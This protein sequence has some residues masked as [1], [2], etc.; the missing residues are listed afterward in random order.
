MK[1]YAGLLGYYGFSLNESYNIK[2]SEANKLIDEYNKN[3]YIFDG[4]DAQMDYQ[5]KILNE[6]DEILKK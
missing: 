3:V 5:R 2:V 4:C 1:Q 6:I